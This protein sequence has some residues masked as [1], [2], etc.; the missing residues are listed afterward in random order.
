M[1]KFLFLLLVIA[2]LTLQAQSVSQQFNVKKYAQSQT[3]SIQSALNLEE[4]T[5][6]KVYKATLLKAH[7]VRKKLIWYENH[8]KTQ[9]KTLDELVKMANDDAE[10]GSGYQ[11]RMKEILGD[12]YN[13]YVNKF[14]KED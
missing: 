4:S 1:K 14:K 8:Q 5:T 7:A 9:G 11:K 3:Q 12:Q 2:G 13:L 10:K 6:Q